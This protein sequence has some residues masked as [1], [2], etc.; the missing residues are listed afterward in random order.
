M[1]TAAHGDTSNTA[2]IPIPDVFKNATVRFQAGAYQQAAVS[3]GGSEV[4]GSDSAP[5]SEDG[6][7]VTFQALRETHEGATEAAIG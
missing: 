2:T 7:Q 3:P 5:G 1:C 4:A 6:A